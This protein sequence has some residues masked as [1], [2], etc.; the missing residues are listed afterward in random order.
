MTH[1]KKEIHY[2]IQKTEATQWPQKLFLIAHTRG[3]LAI[4]QPVSAD[5]TFG[6]MNDS[7]FNAG[8][9]HFM[10]IDQQGNA[11]SERL[12]FVPDRNPHQWQILADKP[13]Y[14]KREKVS[15]Q[16]SAKD[17]N[18][19]PVE[20][21]FSVSITD[22]RSIQP[23]SLAD[24]ILSNLLLTSDLKGCRKSGVLCSSARPAYTSHDRFLDDDARMA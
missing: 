18:G 2:E 4:L 7:L 23:D 15:L 24:N 10:L 17:D 8:I 14:G 22:R 12:V 6:R 21:S 3:K 20:G 11:L 9:T 13:T 19:T 16:I 5:R 1:Y